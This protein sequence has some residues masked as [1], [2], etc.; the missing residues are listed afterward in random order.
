MESTWTLEDRLACANGIRHQLGGPR[1]EAMTGARDFM[2]LSRGLQFRLPRAAKNGIN[3]VRITVNAQDLYDL[4]FYAM[5]G[6]RC[7]RVDGHTTFGI[8][9]EEL[10]RVFTC[11]TGLETSL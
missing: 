1:F 8:G 10:R 11:A 9:C 7:R 3:G 2:A 5:R 4:E 6:T